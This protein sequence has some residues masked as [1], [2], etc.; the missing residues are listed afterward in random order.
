M[1]V[2]KKYFRCLQ[3]YFADTN[4][5]LCFRAHLCLSERIYKARNDDRRTSFAFLTFLQRLLCT[6]LLSV[7]FSRLFITYFLS[8]VDLFIIPIKFESSSTARDGRFVRGDD[9]RHPFVPNLEAAHHTPHL[10]CWQV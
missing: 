2:C 6:F 4:T 1:D 3:K 9:S 7:V 10:V 8:S 5:A